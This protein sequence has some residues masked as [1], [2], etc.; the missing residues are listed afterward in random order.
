MKFTYILLLTAMLVSCA[1]ID[2]DTS[3]SISAEALK[4]P[5]SS[6]IVQ[7]ESPH[8]SMLLLHGTTFRLHNHLKAT[9]AGVHLVHLRQKTNLLFQRKTPLA[10]RKPVIMVA[11]K[12]M[13]L[14]VRRTVST[15]IL[16][17]PL[18]LR[19]RIIR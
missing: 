13:G 7:G 16:K 4:I 10:F 8:P 14:S 11:L 18:I 2:S 6:G 17:R 9:F 15:W 5:T 1:G 19:T 12:G 3:A